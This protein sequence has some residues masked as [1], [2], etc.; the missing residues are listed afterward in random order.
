MKTIVAALVAV[1]T[2]CGVASADDKWSH[3]T[4]WSNWYS[5]E[6]EGFSCPDDGYLAKIWCAGDYCDNKRYRCRTGYEKDTSAQVYSG[7]KSEEDD[8][9]KCPAGYYIDLVQCRGRYCDDVAVRCT[10]MKPIGGTQPGA[11]REARGISEEGGE[12]DSQGREV[13]DNVIHL[14][15]NELFGGFHCT[16][17]YCDNLY[18]QVCNPVQGG[19]VLDDFGWVDVASIK[20]GTYSRSFTVGRDTSEETTNTIGTSATVSVSQTVSAGVEVPGTGSLGSETTVSASVTASYEHATT[21]ASGWNESTTETYSCD[22]TNGQGDNLKLY[23]FALMNKDAGVRN[24]SR[25]YRCHYGGTDRES[26]P[27]CLPGE[28]DDRL[29]T[30]CQKCVEGARP[31]AS[32]LGPVV[33]T[34]S[35]GTKVRGLFVEYQGQWEWAHAPGSRHD[36]VLVLYNGRPGRQDGGRVDEAA[37]PFLSYC[38]ESNCWDR[39]YR[40]DEFGRDVEVSFTIPNGGFFRFK[41]AGSPGHWTAEYWNNEGESRSMAARATASF[42]HRTY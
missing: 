26:T 17:G 34:R 5:E 38:Y 42:R 40:L 15:L 9:W 27:V 39:E 28:C 37:K 11:C 22:Q 25:V 10:R 4:E 2:L 29:A 14:G 35:T 32:A 33:Q 6:N 24:N 19:I 18:M 20:G 16:G 1:A 13:G 31:I 36:S 3:L 30:N 7:W 8:I 12:R 23:V 41:T 21:K